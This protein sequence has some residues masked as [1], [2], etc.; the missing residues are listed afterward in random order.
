MIRNKSVNGIIRVGLLCLMVLMTAG[1][2]RRQKNAEQASVAAEQDNMGQETGSTVQNPDNT[3]QDPD[4]MAREQDNTV[5]EQGNE[6]Q[7]SEDPSQKADGSLFYDY[8]GMINRHIYG[9]N[10]ESADADGDSPY[11]MQSY[12]WAGDIAEEERSAFIDA[13]LGEG[14]S[15]Q[16]PFYEY[17][18]EESLGYNEEG[19]LQLELYY[20]EQTGVGCGIRYVRG[21]EN[22]I[23]RKGFAFDTHGTVGWG[24]KGDL[25]SVDEEFMAEVNEWVTDFEDSNEYDEAGR[26]VHYSGTGVLELTGDTESSEIIVMDFIWREDGTLLRKY[27]YYNPFL[28]GTTGSSAY[29][30]FDDRQRMTY[31]YTYITHGSLDYYYIYDGDGAAPVYVLLLDNDLGEWFPTFAVCE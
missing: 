6:A 13:F 14:A 5:Q 28:F 24:D 9:R 3:V 11:K 8:S 18:A 12:G 26:L 29:D 23:A 19:D 30:Y 31:R 25:F 27:S 1:C 20:D 2:G 15:A 7:E 21:K 4:S 22:A 17:Y 10:S 16:P